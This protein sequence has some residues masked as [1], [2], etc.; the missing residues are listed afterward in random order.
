M[1]GKTYGIY[2]ADAELGA[3]HRPHSYNSNSVMN[4]RG[5]RNIE[6]I[7]VRK[8][9]GVSR[10]YCS[11]GSTT[12]C[13]NLRTEDAWPSL[14]QDGLRKIPGHEH[15]QVLNAGE[16]C[17]SIAQ[18]F[19]LA[20][21]FIPLLHPDIVV[22]YGSGIN[23]IMTANSL[24]ADGRNFDALLARQEWGVFSKNLD[25]ARFLKRNSVLVRLYDY[26]LKKYLFESWAARYR[27]NPS[28]VQIHPWITWN[29]EQTL[30]AYI[31]YAQRQGCRV[32]LVRYGDNG[33]DD[34]FLNYVRQL[35]AKA[36]SIARQKGAVICDV[37]SVVDAHPRRKEL[38]TETGLHVTREGADLVAQALQ[39]TILSLPTAEQNTVE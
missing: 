1:P 4:N 12:Y 36:V 34:W 5:F 23:E 16:I 19:V 31:D 13:Y 11:G 24:M 20:K 33:D 22:L 39:K 37:A 29:F 7:P 25:Q 2:M 14:L 32:I 15:D 10:I 27:N 38:F 17:F 21:R 26:Y 6:D 3:V 9:P 8:G 18:E 30:G 35:R 28:D